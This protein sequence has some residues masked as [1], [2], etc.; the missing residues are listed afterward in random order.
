MA[1]YLTGSI[2]LVGGIL[3]ERF[4]KK[5]KLFND[6]ITTLQI[7]QHIIKVG[8]EK[9][10]YL[11]PKRKKA[12]KIGRDIFQ[13]L[14]LYS[15]GQQ[16][17]ARLQVEKIIASI[18]KIGPT[19]EWPDM[20]KK[21]YTKFAKSFP[22]SFGKGDFPKA[23]SNIDSFAAILEEGKDNP[24][25]FALKNVLMDLHVVV[26]DQNPTGIEEAF[27]SVIDYY[28]LPK[29]EPSLVST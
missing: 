9:S 25:I 17:E 13:A 4:S 18:A 20:V 6:P 26:E 21:A 22:T 28:Y 1:S 12:L 8:I 3:S 15:G 10:E 23:L 19:I 29:E 27:Y 11:H 7:C 5:G 14:N 16:N 24:H 2:E